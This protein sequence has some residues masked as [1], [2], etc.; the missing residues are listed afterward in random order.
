M[1]RNP[2]NGI[3]DY[4]I[5]APE[6]HSLQADINGVGQHHQS[7]E[8]VEDGMANK[9]ENELASRAS[10]ETPTSPDSRNR[11]SIIWGVLL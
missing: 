1:I 10:P 4:P 5:Q 7:I 8:A 3:D 11:P 2:Q 6:H 9:V